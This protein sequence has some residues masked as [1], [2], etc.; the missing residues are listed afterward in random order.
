[1]K[2]QAIRLT[3]IGT[4]TAVIRRLTSTQYAEQP[5]EIIG[6]DVEAPGAQPRPRAVE[7]TAGLVKPKCP[8]NKSIPESALPRAKDNPKL[9]DVQAGLKV[10]GCE[11]PDELWNYRFAAGTAG[12]RLKQVI[13][14]EST[15]GPPAGV[16]P[17]SPLPMS[18]WSCLCPR[19]Q[20]RPSRCSASA[21]GRGARTVRSPILGAV[22]GN[23][24]GQVKA[25]PD[26][27]VRVLNS[28]ESRGPA[29]IGDIV[30]MPAAD[31]PNAELVRKGGQNGRILIKESLA[32]LGLTPTRRCSGRPSGP[33]TAPPTR[34][35]W[36]LWP[37]SGP[38]TRRSMASGSPKCS[39]TSTRRRGAQRRSP[40]H[41]FANGWLADPGGPERSPSGPFFAMGLV[42]NTVAPRSAGLFGKRR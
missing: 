38:A 41:S 33:P 31:V 22:P 17:R 14:W 25:K 21:R 28:P 26:N 3:V 40:P 6:F 39:S 10:I 2:L 4:V 19:R 7:A 18:D 9:L 20:G 27:T 12:S 32:K 13:G 1:M 8:F 42:C 35:G 16:A 36:R 5:V 15:G 34:C 30:G 24:K 23:G 29:T 11:N 37:A